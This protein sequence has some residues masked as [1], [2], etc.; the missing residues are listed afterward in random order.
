MPLNLKALFMLTYVETISAGF[1][2]TNSEQ[3]KSLHALF[4][5]LETGVPNGTVAPRL[6]DFIHSG[7]NGSWIY[8]FIHSD[9]LIEG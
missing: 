4:R 9:G 3:H 1:C 7:V 8:V 5:A 6:H 2:V